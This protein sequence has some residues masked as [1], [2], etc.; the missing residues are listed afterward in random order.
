MNNHYVTRWQQRTISHGD[1]LIWVTQPN[2][3]LL[4]YPR[5]DRTFICDGKSTSKSIE[6]TCSEENLYLDAFEIQF[7]KAEGTGSEIVKKFIAMA[8]ATKKDYDNGCDK[9]I[10]AMLLAFQIVR[11]PAFREALLQQFEGFTDNDCVAF[12]YQANV[13]IK[14]IQALPENA[15]ATP[16]QTYNNIC[17][18]LDAASQAGRIFPDDRP[19]MRNDALKH[20]LIPSL[21]S[22]SVS[23]FHSVLGLHLLSMEW[24]FCSAP[25]G[26]TFDLSSIN[27]AAWN[28]FLIRDLKPLVEYQNILFPLTGK[29]ALLLRTIGKDPVNPVEASRVFFSTATDDEM[30]AFNSLIHVCSDD[31]V[32]SKESMF[33]DRICGT[34]TFAIDSAKFRK[35]PIGAI[36]FGL[37]SLKLLNAYGAIKKR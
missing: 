37:N 18:M 10:L 3:R 22:T 9:Y 28:T 8:S 35:D 4:N 24:E 5:G 7:G 29:F 27:F 14:T 25:A 20:K 2:G 30:D 33:L 19:I 31:C 34:G 36:S 17:L 32:L 23:T 16:I 15:W 12:L 6:A 11:T 13:V 1:E 26:K 21:H